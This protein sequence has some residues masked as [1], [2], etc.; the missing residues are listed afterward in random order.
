[1]ASSRYVAEVWSSGPPPRHRLASARVT[2]AQVS[3]GSI[4]EALRPK[5]RHG[6]PLRQ[7]PASR[8]QRANHSLHTRR[9]HRR[10]H[11]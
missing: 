2:V 3:H 5:P 9:R 8:T 4:R 7:R 11:L 10:G 1:M 6:H